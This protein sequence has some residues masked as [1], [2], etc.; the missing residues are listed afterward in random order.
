M[1][2]PPTLSLGLL[3]VLM[4]APVT[5]PVP[6]L[7][8]LVQDRFLVS[9]FLT[10]LFMSVNMIG[11]LVTAPLAGAIADRIGRQR[12]LIV[13]ALVTDAVCLVALTAPLPFWLFL[14]IRFVEGCA[15]ITALSL[16]LSVAGHAANL[17]TAEASEAA[18]ECQRQEEGDDGSPREAAED[19][20]QCN[21]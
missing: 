21:S 8:G 1:R 19:D 13:A 10:S 20:Y 7:R 3:A 17:L 14:S 15:H 12:T 5:M 16:L 18:S 4:L 11:A 2:I 6:I 9:D